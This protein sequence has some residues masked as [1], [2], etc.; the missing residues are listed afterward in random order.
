MLIKFR[1]P[2]I[3]LF[4]LLPFQHVIW[5]SYKKIQETPKSTSYPKEKHKIM[6]HIKWVLQG[7]LQED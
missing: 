5:N 4:C 7:N 6:A 3:S 2:E 1:T